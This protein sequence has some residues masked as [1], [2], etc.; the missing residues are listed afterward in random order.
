MIIETHA[1]TALLCPSCGRLSWHV[2]SLFS[3]GRKQSF[4]CECGSH[5]LTVERKRSKYWFRTECVFCQSEHSIPFT[6]KEIV[7]PHIQELYCS[8]GDYVTGC[9]GPEEE[10][11]KH[12]NLHRR[13]L[14]QVALEASS[15][16]YFQ[17]SKVMFGILGR[18]Y[19]MAETGELSCTCGSNDLVIEIYPDKVKVGCQQCGMETLIPAALPEDL[20]NFLLVGMIPMSVGEFIQPNRQKL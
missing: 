9:F 19:E 2:L 5:V 11:K 15:P 13:S 6:R 12:F 10:V 16:D 1:V 3:L 18:L 14:T 7:A 20:E 17:D 8:E 4:N